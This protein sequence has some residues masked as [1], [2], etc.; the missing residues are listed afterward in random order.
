MK[1]WNRIIGFV[2]IVPEIIIG[3]WALL[4]FF[5]YLVGP[6]PDAFCETGDGTPAEYYAFYLKHSII[7]AV[8]FI[9]LLVLIIRLLRNKT[10]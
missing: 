7:S 5:G 8:V 1:K 3:L 2:L 10:V 9:A 4:L 6:D